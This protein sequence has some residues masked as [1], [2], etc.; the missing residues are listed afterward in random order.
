[1]SHL[2]TNEMNSASYVKSVVYI[3]L[4]LG[5]GIISPSSKIVSYDINLG[6]AYIK[7]LNVRP[8]NLYS[9]IHS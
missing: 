6:I 9:I 1:M 4:F 5:G 8:H 7:H 2:K 3:E